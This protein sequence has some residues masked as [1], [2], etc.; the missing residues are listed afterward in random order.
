MKDNNFHQDTLPSTPWAGTAKCPSVHIANCGK[1]RVPLAIFTQFIFPKPIQTTNQG[2]PKPIQ[3]T[4]QDFPK[5]IQTA[6]PKKPHSPK[7]TTTSPHPHQPTRAPNRNDP[8]PWPRWRPPPLP[9]RRAPGRRRASTAPCTSW[10]AARSTSPRGRPKRGERREITRGCGKTRVNTPESKEHKQKQRENRKN[11][12]RNGNTH[13]KIGNQPKTKKIKTDPTS[14]VY[15]KT[16][17]TT[18]TNTPQRGPQKQ[19][20]VFVRSLHTTPK[21]TL[22][23]QKHSCGFLGWVHDNKTA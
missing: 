3:T 17:H 13:R 11:Q 18:G 12:Q 7:T 2:F 5:P 1:L 22:F 4:N 20:G 14:R 19:A 21:C 9:G 10:P 15:S 8:L 6:N 23:P 16:H